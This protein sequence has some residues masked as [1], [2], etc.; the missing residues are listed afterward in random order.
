M[1]GGQKEEKT[2]T[3]LGKS[4]SGGEKAYSGEGGKG[5]CL[6][7]QLWEKVHETGKRQ[8]FSGEEYHTVQLESNSGE[9]GE[10][11]FEAAQTQVRIRRS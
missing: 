3:K 5:G 7:G 2:S 11:N 8:R 10:V 9:T 6:E 4:C 1:H